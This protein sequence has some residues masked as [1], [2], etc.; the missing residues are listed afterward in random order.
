MVARRA[1]PSGGRAGSSACGLPGLN[2][3][4]VR[5][6]ADTTYRRGMRRTNTIA[7]AAAALGVFAAGTVAGLAIVHETSADPDSQQVTLVDDTSSASSLTPID[8]SPLPQVVLPSQAA[9]PAAPVTTPAP[10]AT[11]TTTTTDAAPSAGD[12]SH[13]SEGDDDG[14]DHD[15]DHDGDHAGAKPNDHDHDDD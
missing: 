7:I 1:P 11:K 8:S 6:V 9:T 4:L 14:G 12:S 3:T 2:R 10:S 5:E 15:G 13:D